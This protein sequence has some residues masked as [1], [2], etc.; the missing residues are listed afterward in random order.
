MPSK[1]FRY[2]IWHPRERL[3]DYT[4]QTAARSAIISYADVK[5]AL[6]SIVYQKMQ[7]R[8]FIKQIDSNKRNCP[9][10]KTVL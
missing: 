10:F 1:V 6:L 5:K 4:V 7:R 9:I 3:S 2:F 8:P